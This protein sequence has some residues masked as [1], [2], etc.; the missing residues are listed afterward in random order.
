MSLCDLTAG[1]VSLC[2][3]T[4]DVVSLCELTAGVVSCTE[5]RAVGIGEDPQDIVHV[6]FLEQQQQKQTRMYGI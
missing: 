6:R 5:S 4:A 3:L 2:V 1:V